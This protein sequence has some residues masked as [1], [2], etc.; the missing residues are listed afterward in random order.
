MTDQAP[1]NVQATDKEPQMS[2][3]QLRTVAHA[4]VSEW[5]VLHQPSGPS[6]FIRR[7]E[8]VRDALDLFSAELE[9]Y[10]AKLSVVADPLLEIRENPRLLRAVVL[11]GFSIRRKVNRLSRVLLPN[12]GEELRASAV[13]AAYLDVA[14]SAWTADT[15]HTFLD[16]AQ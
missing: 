12:Q 16:A 3:E 8:A 13:S 5:Q 2:D 14:N 6:G 4:V 11:E 10:E 15:F 7:V 1:I 9:R